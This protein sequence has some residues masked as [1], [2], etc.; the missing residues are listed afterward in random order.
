MGRG[1][2]I[3]LVDTRPEVGWVTTEGDLKL[4]EELVHT[5]QK[6]GWGVGLTLGSWCTVVDNYTVGEVGCHDEIVLNN[7]ASLSGVEDIALNHFS[8]YDTLLRVEIGGRL[9]NEVDVSRHTQSQHKGDA[10]KLTTGKML[11]LLIGDRLY[12]HW[13]DNVGLELRMRIGLPDLFHEE[14]LHGTGELRANLLWLVRDVHLWE[15]DRL[16]IVWLQKTSKHAD[17]GCLSGTVLSQKDDDLG[18]AEITS[19]HFKLESSECFGHLRIIVVGILGLHNLGGGLGDLE[20]E[21]LVTETKVLGWDETSKENVDTLTNTEW[22]GHDTIG[23]WYTVEAADVV[24]E[25]VEDRQIVLDDHNIPTRAT[26][27]AKL[28]DEPGGGDAL[29]HIQIGG[30]LVEHVHVGILH[31]H[32]S[33]S[34]TLELT[35]R[36][37]LNG[38][39]KHLLEL[40]LLNEMLLHTTII[41]LLEHLHH[42]SFHGFWDLVN[43]LRLDDGLRNIWLR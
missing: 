38:T 18:V 7:E 21:G 4:G 19:A 22:E 35:S 1:E 39:F 13:L 17:E 40:E 2:Y 23:S 10:L 30:W 25:V 11:N 6:G 43:V 16:F 28:A 26:H 20:A 12:F 8:C 34:E 3:S 36:K 15:L 32:N 27:F 31:S 14:I 37:I 41:L 24:G 33:N 42:G 29:L 5:S 9:I